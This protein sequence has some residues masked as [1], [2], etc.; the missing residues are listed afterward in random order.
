MHNF[1]TKV[2]EVG[3][4]TY[5][6]LLLKYKFKMHNSHNFV[7]ELGIPLHTQHTQLCYCTIYRRIHNTRNFVTEIYIVRR[8]AHNFV[9]ELCIPL[10][11]QH[12]QFYY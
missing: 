10:D 2:Y 7:T 11:A 4:T 1:I 9:I 5:T 8:T 3:Y 6:I 12:K